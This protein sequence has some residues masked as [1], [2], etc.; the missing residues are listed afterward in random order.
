[1]MP[2][3]KKQQHQSVATTMS[4]SPSRDCGRVLRVDLLVPASERA[5]LSSQLA[6]RLVS[7]V[8]EASLDGATLRRVLRERPTEIHRILAQTP[9][10]R[11][12]GQPNNHQV[13][14]AARDAIIFGSSSSATATTVAAATTTVPLVVGRHICVGAGSLPSGSR[15]TPCVFDRTVEVVGLLGCAAAASALLDAYGHTVLAT[16]S[17]NDFWTCRTSGTP[18]VCTRI[19]CDALLPDLDGRIACAKT[20]TAYERIMLPSAEAYVGWNFHPSAAYARTHDQLAAMAI[21]TNPTPVASNGWRAQ[22]CATTSQRQVRP[23]KRHGT[24]SRSTIQTATPTNGPMQTLVNGPSALLAAT[25]VGD[26][27]RRRRAVGSSSTGTTPTT[28]IVLSQQDLHAED[29]ALHELGTMRRDELHAISSLKQSPSFGELPLPGD[30]VACLQ[31]AAL[32]VVTLPG[33]LGVGAGLC[34]AAASAAVEK[35][36]RLV[37]RA[38]TLLRWY[39]EGARPCDAATKI[40]RLAFGVLYR[41]RFG[42]VIVPDLASAIPPGRRDDVAKALT[43]VASLAPTADPFAWFRVTRPQPLLC[44]DPY[45]S[46]RLVCEKRL[47]RGTLVDGVRL[48]A[49]HAAEGDRQLIDALSDLTYRSLRLLVD[50][51]LAHNGTTNSGFDALERFDSRTAAMTISSSV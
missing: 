27:V 42:F 4:S 30:F 34:G 24:P 46:R 6:V 28:T 37:W 41:S 39:A 12:G 26:L 15:E 8:H 14:E 9:M 51:L 1:M 48:D 40:V 2:P 7:G 47:C 17:V 25:T 19:L 43:R 49:R 44:N 23:K 45:L 18:H 13:L 20:G 3:N 31:A 35:Y 32:V 50:D 33:R 22:S 10:M 36:G 11:T 16:V 38:W 21:A 29:D 5:S